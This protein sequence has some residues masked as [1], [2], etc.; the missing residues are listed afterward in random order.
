MKKIALITGSLGLGGL[1]KMLLMIA[2]YFLKNDYYVDIVCLFGDEG[3]FNYK[4]VPS[5]VNVIFFN[6]GNSKTNFKKI[7]NWLSFLKNYFESKKPRI[8]LCMALKI[9]ALC[10]LTI[11]KHTRLVLREM[12]DPKSK[13]RSRFFDGVCFF[14]IRNKVNSIIF[15]TNWE[16]TCYPKRL[17]K[18]GTVIPNPCFQL[19]HLETQKNKVIVTTGRL[20][21]FQKRHDL[22]IEAFSTVLLEHPEYKLLIFGDGPDKEDD[23]LMINKFK[24][25]GRAIL[26]GAKQNILSYINDSECFVLSSDYEGMSN[27]LLEA[28]LSGIP[29][30][31]TDWPGVEDIITN[32]IDGLVVKR[33]SAKQLASAINYIIDNPDKS[34]EFSCNAKKNGFKY[35]PD[36]ILSKYYETIEG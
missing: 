7:R 21:N 20:F 6:N 23:I 5:G 9:A 27:S 32:G 31:S 36:F 17:Q 33:G 30:V 4:N 18:K 1:E 29:C 8:V 2:T 22:L 14:L 25:D 24:L 3:K 10:A 35:E 26:M 34:F 28:F 13:A 12:S 15:Q 19:N 11:P 16:K